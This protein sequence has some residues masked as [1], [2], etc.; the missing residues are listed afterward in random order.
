MLYDFDWAFYTDTNSVG[1]WLKPGGVG[2]GNKCDNSLFI[3]LMKNRRCRDY[4]LSLF[5]EKL[6]SDWSSQAMLVRISDRYNE[7]EPELAQHLSRWGISNTEYSNHLKKF[8][9]YAKN[10]PGRLLYFFYNA[11]GKTEFEHYFSEIARSV[12]LID[13][14]GKSYSYY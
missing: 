12:D 4:F 5:A 1:R 3:A 10:R 8:V 2:D 9:N 13:D 6:K 7:L 14:K 11:L